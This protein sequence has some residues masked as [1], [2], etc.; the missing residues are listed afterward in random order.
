MKTTLLLAMLALASCTPSSYIA[1][2][3]SY[4]DAIQANP[5]AVKLDPTHVTAINTFK[6]EGGFKVITDQGEFDI[7][8]DGIDGTVVVDLSSNK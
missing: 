3:T 2:L 7:N 8:Q 1:D 6:F 5:Q 4:E